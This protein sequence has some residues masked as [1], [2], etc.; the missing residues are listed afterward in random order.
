MK[1]LRRHPRTAALITVAAL[2]LAALAVAAARSRTG[3]GCATPPPAT[4]LP[5]AL[6]AIGDLDQP[7][8]SSDTRNLQEAAVRAASALHSDLATTFVSDPI[9]ITAVPPAHD[10]A[11]V[12]ALRTNVGANGVPRTVVGLVEFLIDCSGRAFFQRVADLAPSPPPDFPITGRDEA[13]ARL[14]T[15]NPQLVYDCDPLAP[16]WRD[17]VSGRAIPADSAAGTCTVAPTP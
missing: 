2:A 3:G 12:F 11:I 10:D 1:S 7:Y 4:A 6:R 14:G 17:P 16:Q 13:A 8:P 9:R 5:D 15:T